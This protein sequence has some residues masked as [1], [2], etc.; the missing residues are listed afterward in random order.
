M[1]EVAERY[2]EQIQT[3]AETLRRRIIAYYDGIFFIANKVATALDRA[4]DVAEPVAYD[5]SDYMDNE[6]IQTPLAGMKRN[7]FFAVV[8]Q[9]AK[10]KIMMVGESQFSYIMGILLIQI[11]MAALFGS[12]PN[13][14]GHD[15]NQQQQQ[16]QQQKH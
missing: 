2:V 16:H 7:S 10:E 11:L 12:D 14:H 4:R 9:C 3:T 1:S 5:V 8:T 15:D 13:A 6:L